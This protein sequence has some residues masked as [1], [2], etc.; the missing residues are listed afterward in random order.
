MGG[1]PGQV[2]RFVRIG[3][4]VE[5]QPMIDFRVNVQL[6]SP[7][8]DRPLVV[9]KRQKNRV[10]NPGNLSLHDGHE[11][12]RIDPGRR[13]HAGVVAERRVKV[14]DV[15]ERVAGLALWHA[16]PL[17]DQ[18][19][20]HALLV[21][22]LFAEQAVTAHPQPVIRRVDHQRVVSVRTALECLHD[23]TNLFVQMRHQA[24]I[25]AKLI[26]DD[27]LRARPGR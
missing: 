12:F 21:D 10:A 5:Q 27:L 25:F 2:P 14:V 7:I 23:A 6:P 18:R 13:R 15:G 22:I 17:Q 4:Q 9:L 26:A 19:T 20:L 11:V 16:R 1:F 3:R 24:V 8:T